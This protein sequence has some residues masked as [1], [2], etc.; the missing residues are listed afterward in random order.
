MFRTNFALKLCFV[1]LAQSAEASRDG[2]EASRGHKTKAPFEDLKQHV[3][4]TLSEAAEGLLHSASKQE[5]LTQTVAGD[6]NRYQEKVHEIA[7]SVKGVMEAK[8]ELAKAYR[9]DIATNEPDRVKP[10]MDVDLASLLEGEVDVSSANFHGAGDLADGHVANMDEHEHL[11]TEA[12]HSGSEHLISSHVAA[13]SDGEMVDG[14]SHVDGSVNEGL[15]H[16]DGASSPQYE[17]VNENDGELDS[18]EQLHQTN[19]EPDENELGSIGSSHMTGEHLHE[20]DP[21]TDENERDGDEIHEDELGEHPHG[22]TG[23]SDG[24]TGQWDEDELPDLADSHLGDTGHA[25]HEDELQHHA[26]D[27]DIQSHEDDEELGNSGEIHEDFDDGALMQPGT[28]TGTEFHDDGESDEFGTDHDHDHPDGFS[29]AERHASHRG[30]KSLVQLD[31]SQKALPSTSLVSSKAAPPKKHELHRI[32]HDSHHL[33]Q[34]NHH[35]QHGASMWA[36]HA[37]PKAWQTTAMRQRLQAGAAMHEKFGQHRRHVVPNTH[38]SFR[39]QAHR[40]RPMDSRRHNAR[41][42]TFA[43]QSHH[44]RQNHRLGHRETIELHPRSFRSSKKFH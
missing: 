44:N 3:Q 2:H 39:E 18:D 41:H 38:R 33:A 17:T 8:Q 15:V 16:D 30:G 24:D 10:L 6:M 34:K 14:H 28:G 9:E 4:Q 31:L 37:K 29:L 5:E 32:S 20:T 43:Q 26:V 23:F 19:G 22:D 25:F 21:L 40:V 11:D 13:Q 36:P 1:L 12:N 27:N 7:D 35:R 42:R